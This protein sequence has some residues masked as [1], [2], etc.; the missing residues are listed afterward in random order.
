MNRGK[1]IKHAN[2]SCVITLMLPGC[3]TTDWTLILMINKSHISGETL[4][5]LLNYIML[6][7]RTYA[8]Q[9]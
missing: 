8:D 9:R 5:V 2:F 3:E 4:R 1:V 7:R 6:V